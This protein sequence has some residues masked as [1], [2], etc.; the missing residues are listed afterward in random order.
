MYRR[1]FKIILFVSITFST[2]SASHAQTDQK[3]VMLSLEDCIVRALKHN[4]NVAIEVFNPRLADISLS[5]AQEKYLPQLVFSINKR[6]TESA[7]YSWL[8]AADQVET[9]YQFYTTQLTQYVPT[10]AY[11]TVSLENNKNITNRRFQTINPRYGSTLTFDFVQ[12]LLRN[13]GFRAS[14]REIIIKVEGKR[15]HDIFFRQYHIDR[16]YKMAVCAAHDRIPRDV[17]MI[18][19]GQLIERFIPGYNGKYSDY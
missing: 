1:L 5:L 3:K 4:L 19:P 13:F 18:T 16:E 12:P 11:F 17:H 9:Q 2:S 14:N 7:S 8:D 15:I 10:G 6:N